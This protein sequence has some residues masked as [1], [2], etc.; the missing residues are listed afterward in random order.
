MPA[1]EQTWRNQ[2]GLHRVFMISGV[3]LLGATLWMLAADHNREWK[4]YQDQA[5]NV[6]LQF[7]EWQQEQFE[8]NEQFREHERLTRAFDISRAAPIPTEAIDE[9]A[10]E[11]AKFATLETKAARERDPNAREVVPVSIDSI[12]ARLA[13]SPEAKSDN[14]KPEVDEVSADADRK[15]TRLNSSH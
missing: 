13:K 9:F 4:R 3:C 12:K 1:T 6:E 5:R 8:T 10:A 2:R 14:A 7:N 15:S 11:L